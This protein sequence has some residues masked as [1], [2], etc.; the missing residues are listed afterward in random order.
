MLP[1]NNISFKSPADAIHAI[2]TSHHSPPLIPSSTDSS[3]N[4]AELG[5]PDNSFDWTKDEAE[6]ERLSLL[7]RSPTPQ[8]LKTVAPLSEEILALLFEGKSSTRFSPTE[9][10]LEFFRDKLGLPSDIIESLREGLA[11]E[12]RLEQV[13]ADGEKDQEKG[14]K[15]LKTLATAIVDR[16][17][18]L[19][20]D[21]KM[22]LFGGV[23]HQKG[24]AKN[25]I[26]N[27]LAASFLPNELAKQFENEGVNSISEQLV[28]KLS[29][30]LKD[31]IKD[32]V[33]EFADEFINL[34]LNGGFHSA[35][36]ESFSGGIAERG[37]K[38]VSDSLKGHLTKQFMKGFSKEQKIDIQKFVDKIIE[39]GVKE[40][41]QEEI[42]QKVLA[43]NKFFEEKVESV[44]KKVLDQLPSQAKGIFRAMGVTEAKVPVWFEVKRQQNKKY[45]LFVHGAGEALENQPQENFLGLMQRRVTLQYHDLTADQLNF[46]FFFRLLTPR[47]WS[48]WSKEIEFSVNQIY[49]EDLKTL[50]KEP[51]LTTQEDYCFEEEIDSLR[52]SWALLRHFS[53]G[54]KHIFS[55]G[56]RIKNDFLIQKEVLLS[57]W[58][59]YKTSPK[60]K[61]RIEQ[62]KRAKQAMNHI[63]LKLHNENRI[64]DGELKEI[65]A[66]L[67]D[68]ERKL[69]VE[70]KKPSV[71]SKFDNTLKKIL[72]TFGGTP[73][74]IEAIQK[75]LIEIFGESMKEVIQEALRE[76]DLQFPKAV[77]E[78]PALQETR[79]LSWNEKFQAIGQNL[80]TFRQEIRE[81][82]EWDFLIFL[83]HLSR[84]VA[85]VSSYI[86]GVVATSQTLGVA[87]H[88]LLNQFPLYHCCP[89]FESEIVRN[90]VSVFGPIIVRKL[91]PNQ[92]IDQAYLTMAHIEAT[93]LYYVIKWMVP[94][95][96]SEER[97]AQVKQFATYSQQLLT[98]AGSISYALK[99]SNSAPSQVTIQPKGIPVFDEREI[100]KTKPG[101]ITDINKLKDFPVP[102]SVDLTEQNILKEINQWITEAEIRTVFRSKNEWFQGPFSEKE[103]L[104][105]QLKN[106]PMPKKGEETLWDRVDDPL[107]I[108]K[109]LIRLIK[110][111]GIKSKIT[112]LEYCVLTIR[113]VF[114]GSKINFNHT[115]DDKQKE[116]NLSLAYWRIYAILD[117][118]ARRSSEGS[119]LPSQT[120]PADLLLLANQ[121]NFVV[122]D[123]RVAKQLRDLY[124][125]YQIESDREYQFHDYQAMIE[126]SIVEHDNVLTSPDAHP[127][128]SFRYLYTAYQ[129]AKKPLSSILL[130]NEADDVWNPST[131][132]F[133]DNDASHIFE[134]LNEVNAY[135]KKIE[136]ELFYN[137]F[138][139]RKFTGRIDP[140]QLY[141]GRKTPFNDDAEFVT[142]H[143]E[144][145]GNKVEILSFPKQEEELLLTSSGFFTIE[146]GKNLWKLI[147]THKPEN[148]IRFLGEIESGSVNLNKQNLKLLNSIFLRFDALWGQLDRY[149]ALVK[150]IG[151][152][153]ET[154]L[155]RLDEKSNNNEKAPLLNDLAQCAIFV[156][157]LCEAHT[158]GS[159]HDFP[160]LRSWVLKKI[161]PLTSSSGLYSE[162]KLELQ[163][164]T[165]LLHHEETPSLLNEAKQREFVHDFCLFALLFDDKFLQLYR[166]KETINF[167][168]LLFYFQHLPWVIGF[169]DDPSQQ[170]RRAQI[171]TAVAQTF[172]TTTCSS[173]PSFFS[174]GDC[175][176]NW[177]GGYPFY[178]SGDLSLNF[179]LYKEK[180]EKQLFSLEFNKIKMQIEKTFSDC[181]FDGMIEI[182]AGQYEV[183]Q[184]NLKIFLDTL[185]KDSGQLSFNIYHKKENKTF[186]LLSREDCQFSSLP[187]GIESDQ[188]CLWISTP[189]NQ[190]EPIE[191][192]VGKPWTSGFRTFYAMKSDCLD[193]KIELSVYWEGG[194]LGNPL[195]ECVDLSK[196]THG[197]ALLSWFTPLSKVKAYR[198]L[199]QSNKISR[200]ELTEHT[201]T[202]DVELQNGTLKAKCQGIFPG[203]F[204]AN[205][206]QCEATTDFSRYLL[207]ENQTGERKVLLPNVPVEQLL[208]KLVIKK[209]GIEAQSSLLKQLFERRWQTG[210][211]NQERSY[212]AYSINK[213]K[214]FES[215]DPEAIAYLLAHQIGRGELSKAIRTLEKLEA[216]GRLSLFSQEVLNILFPLSLMSLID[217]R[218]RL[219]MISLRIVALQEENRLL[220]TADSTI[221]MGDEKDVLRW[222]VHHVAY[223]RYLNRERKGNNEISEQQELFILHSISRKASSFIENNL[224]RDSEELIQVFNAMGADVIAEHLTLSSSLKKRYRFL[225][226]KYSV[227]GEN[228]LSKTDLI[229]RLSGISNPSASISAPASAVSDSNSQKTSLVSGV[230]KN[231]ALEVLNPSWI[232]GEA[233]KMVKSLAFQDWIKIIELNK[234]IS[235]IE[236][237]VIPLSYVDYYPGD[238]SKYFLSY[239]LLAT[240]EYSEVYKKNNVGKNWCKKEREA[241]RRF[242]ST[243]H[244]E[245]NHREALLAKCLTMIINS[246]SPLNLPKISKLKESFN[247]FRA[248]GSCFL[249]KC[250]IKT[251]FDISISVGRNQA[252]FKDSIVGK[253]V[254]SIASYGVDHVKEK[255][256][257]AIKTT[258]LNLISKQLGLTPIGTA[259]QL[260]KWGK[261][262][263]DLLQKI[264]SVYEEEAT[265][266]KLRTPLLTSQLDKGWKEERID[267]KLSS[268]LKSLDG[269]FDQYL[270]QINFLYFDPKDVTDD[271]LTQP[272]SLSK[273]GAKVIRNHTE[274]FNQ[275]CLDYDERVKRNVIHS[276]PKEANSINLTIEALSDAQG[277][278]SSQL[279]LERE[280]LLSFVNHQRMKVPKISPTVKELFLEIGQKKIADPLSEI[281]P[282]SYKEI[283]L[284]F[285]NDEE[286]KWR[287]ATKLSSDQI[288]IVRGHLYV[289]FIKMTRLDQIRR[290]QL[291]AIKA[292]DAQGIDQEEYENQCEELALEL[293]R[294]RAYDLKD[295]PS[296]LCRS[297]LV[298]EA[299]N[300]TLLWDGQARQQDRTLLHEGNRL[301][302]E[303]IMGSGKTFFGIPTTDHIAADGK[304]LV[305]N[306]WPA[307]AAP[308]STQLTVKQGEKTFGQKGHALHFER[309]TRLTKERLWG[310]LRRFENCVKGKEQINM[311]KE[312]P[313]SLELN[314]ILM[315]QTAAEER[316]FFFGFK[317]GGKTEELFYLGRIL[318]MM[319]K[320]GKAIPDEFH[321]VCERSKELD[322]PIGTPSRPKKEWITTIHQIMSSLLKTEEFQEILKLKEDQKPIEEDFYRSHILP[323][324]ANKIVAKKFL[325]IA[326]EDRQ[327]IALYLSNQ[328]N[329]VPSSVTRDPKHHEMIDLVK[330]VISIILPRALSLKPNEN[331]GSSATHSNE[332]FARPFIACNCPNEQSTIRSPFEAIV[333]TYLTFL[334]SRLNRKQSEK[335][336][337]KL[338]KTAKFQSE[339]QN[340]PFKETL[341]SRLFARMC[342]GFDLEKWK[343]SP[344]DELHKILSANDEAVLYYGDEVA[345]QIKYYKK[346]IK[347]NS[348]NFA[349]MFHSF[350]ADTGSLFNHQTFPVGTEVLFDK[351]TQGE[352][353]HLLQIKQTLNSIQLLQ[354]EKGEEVVQEI[355]QTHFKK[356]SLA[357]TMIDRGAISRGLENNLSVARLMLDFAKIHRPDIQGVVFYDTENRLMSLEIGA[358][359]PIPLSES[360]LTP[361]KRLTYFDQVH[362]YASDV[363]QPSRAIA[364]MTLG[365]KTTLEQLAQAVWRMRGLR[366]KQSITIVIGEDLKKKITPNALPTI[367]DI[368]AFVVKNE[369]MQLGE[370]HYESDRQKIHNVIRRAV[371]DKMLSVFKELDDKGDQETGANAPIMHSA[372]DKFLAYFTEFERIL[373]EEDQDCPINLFGGI[374]TM[375]DPKELLKHYMVYQFGR[376]EKSLSFTH[377][378][379]QVI[380][381]EMKELNQGIYPETVRTYV[382]DGEIHFNALD[383][384]GKEQ[385]AET[386]QEQS[387]ENENEMEM[388]QVLEVNQQNQTLNDKKNNTYRWGVPLPWNQQL[389]CFDLSWLKFEDPSI[390]PFGRALKGSSITSLGGSVVRQLSSFLGVFNQPKEKLSTETSPSVSENSAGV[391]L[392]RWSE[393]IA[394]TTNIALKEVSHAFDTPL[395]STH[396]FSP[397]VAG[398][399]WGKSAHHLYRNRKDLTDF[400]IIENIDENGNK[401]VSI[402]MVDHGDVAFWREKL[403]K[404][405]GINKNQVR[406]CLFNIRSNLIFGS[407]DQNWTREELMQNPIF[408]RSIIQAKFYNGDSDYREEE[409]APLKKW[410]KES[411]VEKMKEAF[412]E[413]RKQGGGNPSWEHTKIASLFFDLEMDEDLR[414]SPID[415]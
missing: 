27:S 18:E 51:T 313:Q 14:K 71:R 315:A 80:E 260:F 104:F 387:T 173:T 389:D 105:E 157:S 189:S 326:E 314:M 172:E 258:G 351:G 65:Y 85:Q 354:K 77:E 83:Y 308:M 301:V 184:F 81:W 280:E 405:S 307:P 357:Y 132:K 221:D 28:K 380:W 120:T 174:K 375:A 200:L 170:E 410:L 277:E 366:K 374:E 365:E 412:N 318:Y 12:K 369:A 394:H 136:K 404:S 60:D 377:A 382:K 164:S 53:Y 22:T 69:P 84:T 179:H 46:P 183:P 263:Y 259:Y 97:I 312:S 33:P 409:V 188:N 283:S 4:E 335:L 376:I 43:T 265:Q 16:I 378:E 233:E 108:M 47:V 223:E 68:I 381:G 300:Q 123:P 95:F 325:K 255:A 393:M 94:I 5:T 348:Q 401:N 93:A 115:L 70:E 117:C 127:I 148:L 251:I 207:L 304:T 74:R 413:I 332:E 275:S 341:A 98:P 42:D 250:D 146:G 274:Q 89:I 2:S 316:K 320:Y 247:N 75:A 350:V 26:L 141:L 100:R 92:L 291:L 356:G 215:D 25:Q 55:E 281:E 128:K 197:L 15:S 244:L 3:T 408:V 297:H 347:S 50:K 101:F 169:L 140:Q 137:R 256:V 79:N 135:T 32:A 402:G 204:I 276:I 125:Y 208:A 124:R 360:T 349:S 209:T 102:Y 166:I 126:N 293:Q 121:S 216:K 142:Y 269:S 11:W 180:K 346:N 56:S 186:R 241:L 190:N 371:I 364:I 414:L 345:K 17:S 107:K 214:E 254:S 112:G 182:G 163:E 138:L 264:R 232:M 253:C 311:S 397:P 239:Y 411:G 399:L 66:T 262:S 64:D 116:F 175:E 222:L 36:P 193:G 279:L 139:K 235:N 177:R 159:Q 113:D 40:A 10:E 220:P 324:F 37:L 134:K 76:I 213:E 386:T 181:S 342:P 122:T 20:P 396:N 178:Q 54:R 317:G 266:E 191:I 292:R 212:F 130:G 400:L 309:S 362:T 282:L 237:G 336:I 285:L 242:L 39:K 339:N 45:T 52:G 288:E 158:P 196:E 306:I 1:L 59:A 58:H 82:D 211:E 103:Y 361:E 201:L 171:L 192:G 149:P 368:Y 91:I 152:F 352:T 41:I 305:I 296:R 240:N 337:I 8:D 373:I 231:L 165:L 228:E 49:Q 299:A 168:P 73:Y 7:S 30:Q 144:R 109:C 252:L 267:E 272:L 88:L 151:S 383:S 96:L 161:L 333:K 230:I 388:D 160:D 245:G 57:L 268:D 384:L 390:L 31:V 289:H 145:L 29:D 24:G 234:V 217:S 290:C 176:L 406:I 72:T 243:L 391:P 48:A 38:I 246:S 358:E 284:L 303:L 249:L 86:A 87:H 206:Q 331:F 219:L 99:K 35:L 227:V 205:K 67:W 106:L 415:C 327:E 185:Q 367:E 271:A 203:F 23:V 218:D 118:L 195:L 310:L 295:L 329:H 224:L 344:F 44:Q 133:V 226:K 162:E 90:I 278:L 210:L 398:L 156:R 330:G 225:K 62:L 153:F 319:R 340:I 150:G 114:S 111:I 270:K 63:A 199:T 372:V 407:S 198:D 334:Y 321:E 338:C 187:H 379:K 21:Q 202:F 147:F 370:D 129:I 287:E 363:P 322:Y 154:M 403:K 78:T 34:I 395:F 236:D 353:K 229:L 194:A 131:K 155:Q 328:A 286:E 119:F 261:T 6:L 9:G 110:T 355:L 13:I 19:E 257:S 61:V 323:L 294:G 359:N 167:S 143:K 248:K 385:T 238:I 392:Y 273:E 343:D 298:F 302:T